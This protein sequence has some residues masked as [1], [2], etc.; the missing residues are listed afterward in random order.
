[1][2][3]KEVYQGYESASAFINGLGEIAYINCNPRKQI[4]NLTL[5]FP[6]SE[7]ETISRYIKKKG[8]ANL[9]ELVMNEVKSCQSV[10]VK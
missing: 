7:K 4:Y 9:V 3:D 6:A 10:A 1:M 8:K 2:S 5:S